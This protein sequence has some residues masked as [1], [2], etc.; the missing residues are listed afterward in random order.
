MTETKYIPLDKNKFLKLMRNISISAGDFILN[1]QHPLSIHKSICEYPAEKTIIKLYPT[2]D[3]DL[4]HIVFQQTSTKVCSIEFSGVEIILQNNLIGDVFSGTHVSATE[5]INCFT[6][7]VN[8]SNASNPPTEI[9]R[10]VVKILL[11][12][13][14]LYENILAGIK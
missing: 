5:D 7:I 10:S 11:G 12:D 8:H 4:V 2:Y 13:D 9:E 14:E 6:V 1:R 3:S